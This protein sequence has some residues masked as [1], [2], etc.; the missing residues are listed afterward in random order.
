MK[1][2]AVAK[3][4]L[5]DSSM[6]CFVF[7]LLG[8]VPFIGVPFGIAALCIGGRVR[9]RENECWNAARPYRIWG[10]IFG[11]VTCVFWAAA[12]VL[13]VYNSVTGYWNND[14]SSYSD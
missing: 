7:G 13:I 1:T 3:I 11:G 12:A 4:E 9:K 2:D 6:R 8:F 14:N 5:I 10:V